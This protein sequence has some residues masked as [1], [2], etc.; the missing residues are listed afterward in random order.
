MKKDYSVWI[1]LDDENIKNSQWLSDGFL[2]NER[3]TKIA[4]KKRSK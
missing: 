3:Q 1:K 4:N 2:S